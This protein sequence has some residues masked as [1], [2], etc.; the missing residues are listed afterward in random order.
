MRAILFLFLLSLLVA[1]GTEDIVK[2]YTEPDDDYSIKKIKIGNNDYALITVNGNET[3]L[4]NE[5]SSI[6]LRDGKDIESVF[7]STDVTLTETYKLRVQI[8]REF[9]E[10][11]NNSRQ[12]QENQCKIFTGTNNIAC[13][14]KDSCIKACYS[15]PICG[16]VLGSVEFALTIRD[17][18]VA[19]LMLDGNVSDFFQDL[20]PVMGTK[21]LDNELQKLNDIRE[22]SF[23]LT[24]SDLVSV[25]AICPGAR[26]NFTALDSAI[27]L[28]N[29]LKGNE[30]VIAA[31]ERASNVEKRTSDLINFTE[32]K[33]TMFE[34]QSDRRDGAVSELN[35]KYTRLAVNVYDPELERKYNAVIALNDEIIG[36]ASENLYKQ[37]FA[38][39]EEFSFNVAIVNTSIDAGQKEYAKV[40][41]LKTNVSTKLAK[42][43]VN[44]VPGY[45][46][47]EIREEFRAINQSLSKKVGKSDLLEIQEKLSNM[48]LSLDQIIIVTAGQQETPAGSLCTPAL[49]ILLL[50]GYVAYV[51]K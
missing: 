49:I 8:L 11:Y 45:N 31:S 19:V 32:T 21:S 28:V 37:A 5:S 4:I 23:E 40:L 33:K 3:F 41:I 42:V 7:I 1:A 2:N 25:Y 29:L 34:V 50:L 43:K 10:S 18:Y 39:D 16:K 30:V 46:I 38:K 48:S 27:N 20:R 24:D 22:L 44:Q 17:W 6:L 14:D 51:R 47:T 26:Y 9:M 13:V 12:P 35:D 15:S 36:L